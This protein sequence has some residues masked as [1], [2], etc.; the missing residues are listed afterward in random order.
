VIFTSNTVVE[1]A[2]RSYAEVKAGAEQ[3]GRNP[4]HIKIAALCHPVVA[5]TR[6]EAEDK[7]ELIERLPVE[8][9]SLMLLSE[10]T[11]FDFGAKPIDEPFTDEELASFSGTQAGRDRV[12]RVM[13]DKKPTPRDF[14]TITRRGKLTQPWVGSPKEVAD[15]F[16]EWFTTPAADGFVVGAPC[17]PG[18]YEDFVRLVVPELQRRGLYHNDYAGPTLRENLGLPRPATSP[19]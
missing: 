11:N 17:V 8:A 10:A 9:D 6:A 3:A 18:S 19:R 1:D 16:E 14:I 2:A 12:L 4:D 7:F 5:E 13:G 15:I